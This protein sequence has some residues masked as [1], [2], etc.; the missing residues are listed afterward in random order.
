MTFLNEMNE[1]GNGSLLNQ[2]KILAPIGKGGMG[3]VFLAQDTK[4]DRKVALKILPSEFA[5]NADRMNRFVREA[6]AAS[7]L[8]HPNIITI[9]EIG[10]SNG[11]HF[12]ATEFIDGKTLTEFSKTNPLSYKS[13]TEI[14]IQVASALAEAHSA[15][16]VHRDIKPDNI[17][18]RSNGLVKVLDFGIAK[19]TETA[20]ANVSS[21]DATAIKPQS[22]SPGVIIGTANYMSPEQAKGQTV[23]ARSD[24]FSFGVVL[25][26]LLAGHLP[27]QGE[28]AVETIGAILHK[29]PLPLDQEVPSELRRMVGTCLQKDR[30]SRYQTISA[31]EE[32]ITALKHE[33]EFQSRLEQTRSP[34]SDEPQTQLLPETIIDEKQQATKST[35]EAK[36][37]PP[38]KKVSTLPNPL[39]TARERLRTNPTSIT[40]FDLMLLDFD[41]ERNPE[42][43]TSEIFD[44]IVKFTAGGP[45]VAPYLINTNLKDKSIILAFYIASSARTS[46]VIPYLADNYRGVLAE[47]GKQDSKFK[48]LIFVYYETSLTLEEIVNLVEFY[49][50]KGLTLYFRGLNYL[51]SFPLR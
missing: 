40:L 38:S 29:E 9:Y 17:M 43:E 5:A 49:K 23:D 4:L 18:I 6:K 15:R 7:A 21:E 48:G 24:I 27:F 46:I 33:L 16:I 26:E 11:T 19:L 28:T 34:V 35:N 10:E 2:Y 14:A 12:I 22:T 13:A 41:P 36:S 20:P 8:N 45:F 47:S 25:Y 31:V 50:K 37:P 32:D 44:A 42:I 3:E 1:S 39:A 30:G 51:L